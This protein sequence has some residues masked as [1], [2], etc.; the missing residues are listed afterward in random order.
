[1]RKPGDLEQQM[2]DLEFLISLLGILLSNVTHVLSHSVRTLSVL[3]IQNE[4][5]YC[6]LN[7]VT[8]RYVTFISNLGWTILMTLGSV[9]LK[10]IACNFLAGFEAPSHL[11]KDIS[12]LSSVNLEI[13]ASP[14]AYL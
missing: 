5:S 12:M 13:S 7:Y 2:Y 3:T 1:M 6:P 4:P 14:F 8:V 9:G 11:R 10:L